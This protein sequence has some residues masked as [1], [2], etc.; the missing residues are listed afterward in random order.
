MSHNR[1]CI[2]L[3]FDQPTLNLPESLSLAMAIA[4]VEGE[5]HPENFSLDVKVNE[6]KRLAAE[7]RWLDHRVRILGAGIPLPKEVLARCLAVSPWGSQLAVPFAQQRSQIVLTY[8]GAARSGLEKMLCLYKVAAGLQ[9]PHLLG[10][11]NEP[12]WNAHPVMDTLSSLRIRTYRENIPF[13]LWFGYPRIPLSGHLSFLV[14]KGHTFFG[15]PELAWL[16]DADEDPSEVQGI[17]MNLFLYLLDNKQ[18][19]AVGDTLQMENRSGNLRVAEMPEME[20]LT[21]WGVNKTSTLLL[22]EDQMMEGD[23]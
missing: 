11:V 13:Q 17:F 9:T 23:T 5:P 22:E 18:R 14:S 4:A 2:T 20:L 12:A 6:E 15:L 8:S 16:C 7:A 19:L 21:D 1:P 3:L 10:I